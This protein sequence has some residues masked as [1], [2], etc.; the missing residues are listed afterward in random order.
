MFAAL[1]KPI[2]KQTTCPSCGCVYRGRIPPAKAEEAVAA[3]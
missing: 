3:L 2:W 1:A